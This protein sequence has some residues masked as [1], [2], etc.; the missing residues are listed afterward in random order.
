LRNPPPLPVLSNADFEKS[1]LKS[2]VL[3]GWEATS[4]EGVTIALDH[5]RPHGGKSA[6]KIRS[7]GP[8]AC[9]VSEPFSAPTTGRLSMAVWLR[10][11][12]PARQPPF[13]LAV[14]G[15][16]N[17]RDY[18]RFAQ[19]GR[20]P[21]GSPPTTALGGEWEQFIFQV[22]DLPLTGLSLLRVRFDLMGAGEVCVDDVQLFD[23][24]FS[25]PEI[26]ELSKLIIL[27]DMKLQYAQLG[28]CV[29][30][31]EG[32]WPRFL[33]ENV[34]LSPSMLAK[35]P[36]AKKPPSEKSAEKPAE[37]T[38]MMDRVKNMIPESL[39]F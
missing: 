13:R 24:A 10:I 32:Y 29:R 20:P 5:S 35:Q 14:E 11:E 39:R 22:D 15:K 31:L 4:R 8:I 12:D 1:I 2:S 17:G 9:L 26:I 36:A 7:N 25:N 18:Y 6:T 3:P 21:E 33:N 30:L 28:D 37:T 27:A 23:L 19:V 16:L 34:P 38:G